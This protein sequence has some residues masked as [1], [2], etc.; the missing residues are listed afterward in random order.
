MIIHISRRSTKNIN[1]SNTE[2][3]LRKESLKLK[4]FKLFLDFIIFFII[5]YIN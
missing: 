2:R 3:M 1:N 4:Y 5:I